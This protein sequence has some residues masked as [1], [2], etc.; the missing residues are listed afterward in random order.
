M[1]I[2][3]AKL[4]FKQM[5]EEEKISVWND[6]FSENLVGGNDIY[7]LTEANLQS[8]LGSFEALL[9]ACWN[10]ENTNEFCPNNMWFTY[11]GDNIK[12]SDYFDELVDEEDYDTEKFWEYVADY[13][14]S[15]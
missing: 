14:Q 8:V 1:S 2:D 6:Y 7:Q 4:A 13:L 5:G 11:D 10:T 3:E 12:T 15:K 9:Y